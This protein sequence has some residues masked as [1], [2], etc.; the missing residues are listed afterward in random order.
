MC[1][2]WKLQILCISQIFIGQTSSNKMETRI[3]KALQ[4]DELVSGSPGRKET[5]TKRRGIGPEEGAKSVGR[6]RTAVAK[7][8]TEYPSPSTSEAA[9]ALY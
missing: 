7:A 9:V 8:T 1:I 3:P 6:P 4:P 5:A 2:K